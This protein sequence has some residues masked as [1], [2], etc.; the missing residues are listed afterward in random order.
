MTNGP[1]SLGDFATIVNVQFGTA[2]L[3]V[4]ILGQTG[5]E[6]SS[7]P[8]GFASFVTLLPKNETLISNT[9]LSQKT[10]SNPGGDQITP[11]FS[12]WSSAL[13]TPTLETYNI[14]IASVN[15]TLDH[16]S[17]PLD[18][19]HVPPPVDFDY[20][21][22]FSID[23]LD[24]D[25]NV[26]N[27]TGGAIPG[28]FGTLADATAGAASANG[29]L[30]TGEVIFPWEATGGNFAFLQGPT[31]FTYQL[32]ITVTVQPSASSSRNSAIIIAIPATS[33]VALLNV[34]LPSNGTIAG[35]AS[36]FTNQKKAIKKLS[37]LVGL[38]D[39]S[40]FLPEATGPIMLPITTTGAIG[41][42]TVSVPNGMPTPPLPPTTPPQ[43]SGGGG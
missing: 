19:G 5:V 9:V 16:L 21:A 18:A 39:A 11:I 4:N 25:N 2:Y 42:G 10:T 14:S 32:D 26:H 23:W 43:T 17:F 22:Q 8:P 40:V 1:Y 37:D 35:W 34:T 36:V 24:A 28:F 33:A 3:V 7:T 20:G 29:A 6:G 12:F 41:K 30:A 31:L 38:P 27:A 15:P 13:P